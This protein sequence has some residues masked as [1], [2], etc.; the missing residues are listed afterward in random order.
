M[1]ERMENPQIQEYLWFS[2]KYNRMIVEVVNHLREMIVTCDCD[3]Q[4]RF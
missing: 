3:F 2:P 4:A 1:F